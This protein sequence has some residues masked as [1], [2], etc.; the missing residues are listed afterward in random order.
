MLIVLKAL[1]YGVD[2]RI[3]PL[4]A[5]MR[6]LLTASPRQ[7]CQLTPLVVSLVYE[8]SGGMGPE[9]PVI[10]RSKSMPVRPKKSNYDLAALAMPTPADERED[11]EVFPNGGRQKEE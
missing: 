10:G 5:S 3:Q 1:T 11:V 7:P 6:S 2:P 9:P 8:C 4:G